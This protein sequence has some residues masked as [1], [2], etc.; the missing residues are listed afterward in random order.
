MSDGEPKTLTEWVHYLEAAARVPKGS[1]DYADA[2]EAIAYAQQRI[3]DLNTA[4]GASDQEQIAQSDAREAATPLPGYLPIVG[5]IPRN[6]VLPF[7][8]G[9]SLGAGEPIAGAL[10][11]I[12]GKGFGAGAQAYREGISNLET[13]NPAAAVGSETAGQ[14]ATSLVPGEQ[15]L[16][17]GRGFVESIV[18]KRPGVLGR[19]LTGAAHAPIGTAG[20]LGAVQGFSSGGEDPG[21]FG[22][23]GR[24][25]LKTAGVSALMAA[26]LGGLGGTSVSRYRTKAAPK[27]ETPEPPPLTQADLEAELQ[28]PRPDAA[29]SPDAVQ[30]VQDYQ[31]GKIS[32]EDLSTA[33]DVA[34]GR[35]PAE[36]P[37]RIQGPGQPDMRMNVATAIRRGTVEPSGNPFGTPYR[38]VT[39]DPIAQSL[40]GQSLKPRPGHPIFYGER[41]F[42]RSPE[43][44]ERIPEPGALSEA[45]AL[46]EATPMQL[47]QLLGR[48]RD[49]A[50]RRA[51]QAELNRRMMGLVESGAARL[52]ESSPTRGSLPQ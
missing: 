43:V 30:A 37:A 11:A 38:R 21:D 51:I 50:T 8:H 12:R 39:E 14:L 47:R 1:P 20:T 13:S 42:T 40:A 24:Q 27:P 28:G 41:S 45:E 34:A 26:I 46:A 23:R 15:A 44:R 16:R 6:V 19:F 36:P 25:A 29:V 33:L 22:A 10:S 48:A 3:H 9:A 18:S 35:T 5:G 7:A 52:T 49:A 32:G 17:G 4:A 2:R 31:A